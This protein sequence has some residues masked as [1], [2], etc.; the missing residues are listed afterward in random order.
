MEE[1]KQ[2]RQWGGKL[3]VAP[4]KDKKDIKA[5]AVYRRERNFESAHLK[6][7]LNGFKKF[8]FGRDE[9]GF[10]MYHDVKERWVTA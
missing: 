10:P 3:K 1:K 5:M 4:P 2:I 9:N 6:A 7:Y 8:V